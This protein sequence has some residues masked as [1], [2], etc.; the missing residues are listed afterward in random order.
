M[1]LGL[2]W[3]MFVRHRRRAQLQ[4]ML[5]KSVSGLL[6]SLGSRS[7]WGHICPQNA[8]FGFAAVTR[9]QRH[10][11]RQSRNPHLVGLVTALL[12]HLYLLTVSACGRWSDT[13]VA[14]GHLRCLATRS[15]AAQLTV[16]SKY[17]TPTL[18]SVCSRCM[19]IPP[20]CAA[21]ISMKPGTS[22]I[23]S[24]LYC[25]YRLTSVVLGYLGSKF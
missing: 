7:R 15:S 22:S 25:H 13:L 2:I 20:P 11:S 17:G 12:S 24:L 3:T 16:Q 19:D 9:W 14:S 21:C 6:Q 5:A 1:I 18:A 8:L 10:N 4:K 23:V